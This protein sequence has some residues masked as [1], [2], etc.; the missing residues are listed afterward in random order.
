MNQSSIDRRMFLRSL[1]IAGAAVTAAPLLYACAKEDAGQNPGAGQSGAVDADALTLVSLYGTSGLQAELGQEGL[2]GLRLVPEAFGGTLLDRPVEIVAYD[3]QEAIDEA[4]RRV[5]ESTEAGAKFFVGGLLSSTALAIGEE[6]NKSGGVFVTAAGADELTGSECQEALFRWSVATHGAIQ[7]T[8]LRMIE[9]D[10]SRK[11]WYTITPDY[12]FGQALLDNAKQVF[13][14]RGIEHVGN[15]LHGLDATEFS[16]YIN[17][18]VA[19][20]PDVLCI[21]NFGAQSTTTIQQAVAF[22]VKNDMEILLAWS[23]GLSQFRAL[24]PETLEGIYAGAQYWH[25][26]DAPGNSEFVDMFREKYDKNPSY[27]HAAGYISGKLILDGV[28]AAG[29][30]DPAAVVQ[31]LEGMKYDGPTG[32]E[33]IRAEDHQVIKD[34]YLMKGKTASDMEDDDDLMEILSSG[35][36]VTAVDQTGCKLVPLGG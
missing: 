25:T 15:S 31:E 12:V 32:E 18:A 5:R 34:Y 8:V 1:G 14:E 30:A 27:S 36:S 10:S 21:L 13:A 19:K 29:S 6:V 7:E 2:D 33:T 16:G 17:N 20:K 9:S 22:G 11:R 23:G 24:G 3:T 35:Q 4:V 26:V 28:R